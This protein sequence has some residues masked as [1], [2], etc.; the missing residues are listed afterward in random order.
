MPPFYNDDDDEMRSILSHKTISYVKIETKVTDAETLSTR[1]LDDDIIDDDDHFCSSFDSKH[2]IM[3]LSCF[4]MI[5]VTVNIIILS[6]TEDFDSDNWW[7]ITN[8]CNVCSGYLGILAAMYR[9][10]LAV[11][12]VSCWLLFEMC[13]GM[14]RLAFMYWS[15]IPD[16]AARSWFIAYTVISY[17]VR[18]LLVCSASMFVSQSGGDQTDVT[19]Q[20]RIDNDGAAPSVVFV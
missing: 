1:L 15:I 13:L 6:S 9:S 18:L 2:P 10:K 20:R 19:V 12:L 5:L 3:I 17:I 16:T 11:T 4:Y 14:F 8:I 7:K